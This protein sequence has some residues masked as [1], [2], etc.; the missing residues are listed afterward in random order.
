MQSLP[1]YEGRFLLGILHRIEGDYDN[2]SM[3]YSDVKESEIYRKVWGAERMSFKDAGHRREREGGL[4]EGQKF[5]GKVQRCKESRGW[6]G[7]GD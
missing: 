2:A 1:A 6:A 3:W 7:N 4:D 5:L